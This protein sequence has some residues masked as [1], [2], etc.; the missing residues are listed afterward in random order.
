MDQYLHSTCLGNLCLNCSK[1]DD[2]LK[3]DTSYDTQVIPRPVQLFCNLC[4][5]ESMSEK[6]MTSF[7]E[8]S[9][10]LLWEHGETDVSQA[11]KFSHHLICIQVQL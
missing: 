8:N 3:S 1:M 9:T 11:K 5:E 7:I 4:Y 2:E 10:E 6:S